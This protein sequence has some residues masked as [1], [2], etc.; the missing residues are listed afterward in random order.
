VDAAICRWYRTEALVRIAMVG[1]RG[2]PASYSGFETFVE[3]LGARLVER[4]HRVT[5]YC[6]R[7]H[8]RFRGRHY[9]GMRLVSLPTVRNKYLDTIV[10]TTLS[11]FHLLPR[12]YD[13]VIMCIAGN[14]PAAIIPRLGGKRVALNVDGLD[15]TREKWPGP[16]KRYLRF[17]EWLATKFADAVVT[18]S[19]SV[20]AYYR[21]EHGAEAAYI[22]YGT[23]VRRPPPGA[24]LA[25]LGLEPGRYLLYVGRLV[26]ENCA[27]QLVEAFGQLRPG[28]DVDAGMKCVIVGDAPYADAYIAELKGRAGPNVIFPG[29]LFGD[30]YWELNSHAAAYVFPSQA[31]GMHPA[32]LEALACGNCTIVADTPTNLETVGDAALPY[33]HRRGTAALVERLREV[34]PDAGLRA[35]WGA[36]ARAH[37]AARYSWERTTD[38][39]EA[40]FARLLADAGVGR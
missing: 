28:V 30:G 39:Y 12:A 22:P 3:E 20:A 26:P 38:Q 2:V 10:H 18:D 16:A 33:D 14:S 13:I 4:R 34:L 17:A 6:R 9:R 31:S 25:R 8:I 24:T 5:V 27:H 21:E 32:L 36:R 1:T 19:R 29:Y 7:H 15:W 35:A 11:C 23:A 40:L 37:I